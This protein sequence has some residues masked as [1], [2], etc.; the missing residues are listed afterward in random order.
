MKISLPKSIRSFLCSV[1]LLAP[2][3][4]T[5]SPSSGT[6]TITG[7]VFNPASGEYV[8]NATIVIK[9][10]GQQVISGDGG[11]YR[12][13]GVPTGPVTVLVN[14]T[15][16]R[17][18][19]TSVDVASGITARQDIDIVSTETTASADGEVLKLDSFVVSSAREGTAK[20]IMEQRNSMNVTNTVAT[21]S[22][23]ENPEGNIAEF[24]RFMPGVLIDSNYGEGRYAN[25][26]GL[27]S[28]YTGVTMDGMPLASTDASNTGDSANGRSFSF[29]Q[30]SISSV[31]S[32]EI[33]KTISADVDASSPAGSINL[34][35]K[36]A[37]DRKGRRVSLSLN[38]SMHSSAF[39]LGKTNGPWHGGPTR[40]VRPG[41]SLEYSDV[42][43]DGRLGF[44]LSVS[45]SNIYEQTDAT[46]LAFN[47]SATVADPRP[48][49]INTI[50]LASNPRL[51]QR[52]AAALTV[53][54]KATPDLSFGVNMSY[55]QSD[56]WTL[57]RTML[58][59]AGT[60]TAVTGDGL[61]SFSA[62]ANNASISISGNNHVRK[63][64]ESVV[65]TPSVDWKIGNLT[66][67][68]RFSY[69]RAESWYDNEDKGTFYSPSALAVSGAKFTAERSSL[70]SADWKLTQT[71]GPDI[72][73][74]TSFPS[75]TIL[76]QKD[77]RWSRQVF[78]TSVV[79]A[80]L[81]T[82]L[83]IP[84]TWKTGV[85][86]SYQNRAYDNL[87]DLGRYNYVG[88]GSYWAD[89][90]SDFALD[91]SVNGATITSLSGDRVFMPDMTAVFKA[92]HANPEQYKQVMTAAYAYNAWV[93]NRQRFE[94]EIEAAYFMGTAQLSRNASLRAGLR[95]ER[96]T[97]IAMQPDSYSS[98][99]VIAAGYAVDP[100]TGQATTVEGIAYQFMSRPWAERT[101]S[102]DN[103]F[104]SAS[105]KY[106]LPWNLDFS[107]GYSTTIRRAPYSSLSGAVIVND[108]RQR[109]TITNPNLLPE[110]AQNFA[111]RLARYF[112]PIGMVA[113]SVYENQVKEKFL[114]TTVSA[115][116]FGNTNPAFDGYDFTTTVNSADSV[117]IRSMEIEFSQNLGYI[118]KALNRFMILGSYTHSYAVD[119][120][121]NGLTPNIA[122]GGVNYT[123]G[124]RGRYN[125]NINANWED[126]TPRS[127]TSWDR[128]RVHA[129]AGASV[130]L[131]NRVTLTVSARNIFDTPRVV[132]QQAAGHPAMFL[133]HEKNGVTT[134]F[135]V[136]ARF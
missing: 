115:E 109:V 45:E 34:R 70:T 136:K 121:L 135:A 130:K 43:M 68:G 28:E 18:T 73:K 67:E 7:R 49:V 55:N 13:T 75:S 60:R 16:H 25:V 38:S 24:V 79:N 102:F 47:R 10:T 120:T 41:G 125:V 58:F 35:S 78:Y 65:F 44:V 26:R 90:V 116:E 89:K 52:S 111:V 105:L 76:I 56:L 32:I 40:K 133:R 37:F 103:F 48:Q 74:A 39:T 19:P 42:M 61:T 11:E 12:L 20:A 118:S 114:T 81:P 21:D 85:K 117:K 3:V 92:F 2:A 5:A 64:G 134:T 77:G 50:T 59:T 80:T 129:N 91:T 1:V 82:V 123:F 100:S 72:S 9:E 127:T 33:A 53:D 106:Q 96:T 88:G 94:E 46:T 15:G 95:W 126:D 69:S 63:L 51:Y 99:E 131:T 8:R 110:E 128:A 87:R 66:I 14:Y 83:G 108:E 98:A 122:T 84:V 4:M 57:Q 23:G 113:V 22:F 124:K 30:V 119:T 54:F 31:D 27:G 132:M 62:T 112:E 104:P 17:A 71:A 86:H 6:G 29:E 97:N 101:S 36:R 107:A 93:A